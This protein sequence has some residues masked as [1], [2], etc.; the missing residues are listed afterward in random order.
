MPLGISISF[1]L[2]TG[3]LC[4]SSWPC[5]ERQSMNR[6]PLLLALAVAAA[7][8]LSANTQTPQ[9]TD[10][11]DAYFQGRY[12]EA[13]KRAAALEDLGPLRLRVVQDV[14]AWIRA[15]PALVEQRR[16]AAAAF[17]LE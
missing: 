10:F 6:T 2:R 17:L 4:C 15:D 5:R 8:T 11:I 7:V 9:V 3:A 14:P 1:A 16:A 12:D 13:V